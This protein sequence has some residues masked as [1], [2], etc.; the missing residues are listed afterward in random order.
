MPYKQCKCFVFHRTPVSLVGRVINLFSSRCSYASCCWMSFEKFHC[1]LNSVVGRSTISGEH[2]VHSLVLS[3]F[4]RYISHSTNTRR[5]LFCNSKWLNLSVYSWMTLISSS[6]CMALFALKLLSY[7][8]R[9]L[10]LVHKKTSYY[11]SSSIAVYILLFSPLHTSDK[12]SK[13]LALPVLSYRK[14]YS[15]WDSDLSDI[16]LS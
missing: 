5:S 1:I 6:E 9:V 7:L 3:S 11:R 8:P 2:C 14:E 4:S 12:R 15:I 13:Q 10:S 16:P